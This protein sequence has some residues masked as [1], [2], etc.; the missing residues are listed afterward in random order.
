MTSCVSLA[1]LSPTSSAVDHLNILR[2]LA[3]TSPLA[4]N[5]VLSNKSVDG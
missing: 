4:T 3:M 5:K 1:V 2:R